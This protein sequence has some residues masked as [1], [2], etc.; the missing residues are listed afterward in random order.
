MDKGWVAR[1]SH[2]I[3]PPDEP[4]CSNSDPALFDDKFFYGIALQICADCPVK[5]WCLNVV[6]PANNSYDGVVGGHVWQD[7]VPQPRYKPTST[8]PVL[9]TYLHK[10]K[11]RKAVVLDHVAIRAFLV[12]KLPWNRLTK[13]ERIEAAR[14][15]FRQGTPAQ[16]CA[17]LTRLHMNEVEDIYAQEQTTTKR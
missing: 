3:D 14:N 7:G 16:L 2:W 17:D 8:D 1:V 12:G 15:M 5:F 11:P 9:Q 6:D 13:A 10:R 4:N